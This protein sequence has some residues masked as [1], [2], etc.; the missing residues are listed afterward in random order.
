MRRRPKTAHRSTAGSAQSA[1]SAPHSPI[2]PWSSLHQP[3][4]PPFLDV[5][6]SSDVRL[7]YSCPDPRLSSSISRSLRLS[8]AQL[9][10]I[11]VVLVVLLLQFYSAPTLVTLHFGPTTPHSSSSSPLISPQRTCINSNVFFDSLPY[12]RPYKM[13]LKQ[14]AQ[15]VAAEFDY[16]PDDVRRGVKAFIEQMSTL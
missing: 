14:E 7:S 8:S 4:A 12:S 11:F 2:L 13:S 9:V 3:V 6:S 10:S 16:T 1:G 5:A 15:R